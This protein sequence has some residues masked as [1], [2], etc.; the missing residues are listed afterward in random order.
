MHVARDFISGLFSVIKV[1]GAPMLYRYPYRNSAEGLRSDWLN[2]GQDIR[3]LSM[4]MAHEER[5][6][7]GRNDGR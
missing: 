7:D 2:L 1:V 5:D 6:G 3:L 4:T